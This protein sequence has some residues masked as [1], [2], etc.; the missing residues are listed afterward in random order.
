LI[1]AGGRPAP[2]KLI[3]QGAEALHFIFRLLQG[4]LLFVRFLLRLVGALLLC[5]GAF[6]LFFGPFLLLPGLSPS[7]LE[8]PLQVVELP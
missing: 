8:A 6:L 4:G 5:I 7:F 2:R 3:E 1:A